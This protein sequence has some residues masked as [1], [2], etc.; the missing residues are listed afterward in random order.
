MLH[1]IFTFPYQPA[2]AGFDSNPLE[3]FLLDKEVFEL[4]AHFFLREGQPYWTV[5]VRYRITGSQPVSVKADQAPRNERDQL[6]Y[7]RLRNW[8]REQAEAQGVPPY[9]IL[10]NKQLATLV[11]EKI[12]T[13][14][15]LGAVKGIGPKKVAR[16]GEAII[17]IIE[18]FTAQNHSQDA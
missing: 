12:D 17:G 8:R 16:Y 15:S 11:Q 9:I 2:L 4:Q 5:W 14:A 13:K 3:R 1:K 18:A 7:D 10:T 6:L